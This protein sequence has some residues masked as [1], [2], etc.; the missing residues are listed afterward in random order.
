[1]YENLVKGKRRPAGERAV[2][3]GLWREGCRERESGME[4]GLWREGCGII[5][6][7]VINA[8]THIMVAIARMCPYMYNTCNAGRQ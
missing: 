8:T 4:R 6:I 7:Q 5:Q 2:E 1:M 3:R